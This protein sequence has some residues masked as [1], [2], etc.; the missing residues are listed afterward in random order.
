MK[1]D[2][3]R[4][5]S[6]FGD[7]ALIEL[8][9]KIVPC[10]IRTKKQRIV[11]NDFVGIN[12]D[13]K[14]ILITSRVERKNLF[15]RQNN[16]KKKLIA[17]NLDNLYLIIASKPRFSSETLISMLASALKENISVSIV[18]NKIDLKK[19]TEKIKETLGFISPFKIQSRDSSSNFYLEPSIIDGLNSK[20]VFCSTKFTNGITE[21]KE[22]IKIYDDEKLV[23]T[24]AF[25]GQ[26]GT[27]KS[28]IINLII[29]DA[30]IKTSSISNSLNTGKHTTTSSKNYKI[31]DKIN[32]KVWVI[33]TPGIEKF[34]IS[35][36]TLNDIKRVFP[37]WEKINSK[38]GNCKFSNC[39]HNL[40]PGC[41]I[42]KLLNDLSNSHQMQLDYI[43][44]KTRLK[45]WLNLLS[46]INS[47]D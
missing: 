24:V 9:N 15:F 8:D 34:G 5:I 35:H 27:G 23:S 10:L 41:Q 17:A 38:F 4:V 45:I 42:K 16:E 14:P 20:I 33:D 21:L 31:L 28:S 30:K 44:L 19:E 46:M 2:I 7:R 22:S 39:I 32:K 37:E 12:K 18:L 25:A 36:L 26:S 3:H 47:K 29:P 6:T 13:T 40:E 1:K 11:T 43:N